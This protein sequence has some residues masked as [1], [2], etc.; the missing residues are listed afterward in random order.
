MAKP[1]KATPTLNLAE[2]RCFVQEM[3]ATEKRKINRT[4]QFFVDALLLNK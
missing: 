4:E 1:I 3:R 2:S